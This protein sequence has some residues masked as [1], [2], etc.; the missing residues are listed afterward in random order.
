M[1]TRHPRPSVLCR[2]VLC[3]LGALYLSVHA[4]RAPPRPPA[5]QAHASEKTIVYVL[6]CACVD[7]YAAALA[8]L[9]QTRRLA[10]SALHGRMKQAAREATLSAYAGLPSGATVHIFPPIIV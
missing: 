7:F 10:V 8:R 4:R 6:T 5:L 3:T 9:P 1:R 2:V